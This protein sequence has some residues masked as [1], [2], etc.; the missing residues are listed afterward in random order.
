[1]VFVKWYE[2]EI[3][4]VKKKQKQNDNRILPS[5]YSSYLKWELLQK[6]RQKQSMCGLRNK[7]KRNKIRKKQTKNHL[8]TKFY[9]SLF[10]FF[11][12]FT[13]EP[14]SAL[15]SWIFS[16]TWISSPGWSKIHLKTCKP[17]K[18]L[19]DSW[20]LSVEFPWYIKELIVGWI[21]VRQWI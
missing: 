4:T 7:E 9:F 12:R 19:L 18:W 6:E 1:M 20:I 8:A 3:F 15:A 11:I 17:N 13:S 10:N 16:S 5:T 21:E 2:I 14:S